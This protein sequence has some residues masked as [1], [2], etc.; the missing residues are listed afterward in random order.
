MIYVDDLDDAAEKIELR[1]ADTGANVLLAS[2]EYE[3]VFERSTVADGVVYAAPSQTAVDLLTAPGRG[4]SEAGALLD[5]M[6]SNEP[7]WR[8]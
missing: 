5:W 3:V 2:S 7:A 6:E 8:R 1:A 4:P